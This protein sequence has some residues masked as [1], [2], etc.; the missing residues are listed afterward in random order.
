M[1]D[2]IEIVYSPETLLFMSAA[3]YQLECDLTRWGIEIVYSPETLL[4]PPNVNTS[5]RFVARN[6]MK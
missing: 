5:A 2:R 6:K 3:F 4:R 1:G